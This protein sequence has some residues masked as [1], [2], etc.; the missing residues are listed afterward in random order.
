M[1]VESCF[2]CRTLKRSLEMTR[3]A[4]YD[5]QMMT[6]L[7]ILS[8]TKSHLVR[9]TQHIILGWQ[10]ATSGFTQPAQP[11]IQEST[12]WLLSKLYPNNS[13][14]LSKLN[15]GLVNWPNTRGWLLLRLRVSRQFRHLHARGR[16][17]SWVPLA[18]ASPRSKV[19]PAVP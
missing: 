17:S 19:V 2:C 14:P 12:L 1:Q 6:S 5:C 15:H 16:G 13:P 4:T 3:L 9:F 10:T 11:T 7:P 18:V 8:L